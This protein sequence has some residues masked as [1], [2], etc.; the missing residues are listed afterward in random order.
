MASKVVSNGIGIG[1][2][3]HIKTYQP[4]GLI[5]CESTSVELDKLELSQLRTIEELKIIREKT[6]KEL[7]HEE[8]QI[9]EAHLMIIEDPTLL[10]QIKDTITNDGIIAESAVEKVLDKMKMMFESMDSDYMKER[11]MDMVDIKK[12]WVGNFGVEEKRED[13]DKDIILVSEEL[14]PSDLLEVDQSKVV[15][16]L[17]EKGGC[18]ISSIA[19]NTNNGWLWLTKVFT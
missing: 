15:G 16:I 4:I 3:K 5:E 12:R 19:G 6:M 2:I 18:N 1:F 7:G 8:A 17:M 14:L 13:I 11:A 9:F 10:P